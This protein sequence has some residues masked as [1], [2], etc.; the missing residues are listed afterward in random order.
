MPMLI[1]I[2]ASM[3]R[4]A[5]WRFLAVTGVLYVVFAGV[6]F[7]TSASFSIPHVE[8]LCGQAPPDVQFYTSPDGVHAFLANCGELGRAAYRNLQ[9]ADLFYPAVSGLF[10]AS[11]LALILTRNTRQGSLAVAAAALP[12]LGSG[13][14]YIEN[15]AA[16]VALTSFPGR[17]GTAEML[18][19]VASAA[20]QMAG[21]T[22][23]LLLVIG[24]VYTLVRRAARRRPK[25][26]AHSQIL[27]RT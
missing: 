23:G 2:A 10:M 1:R 19:G 5:N 3:K 15:L 25:A 12:L 24:V 7:A 11:A 18:L 22:A 13:F 21:W 27:N 26:T 9:V 20:K 6:L 17:T 16:W 4:L 8:T 14:D